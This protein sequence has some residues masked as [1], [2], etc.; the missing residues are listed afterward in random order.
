MMDLVQARD[1]IGKRPLGHPCARQ[2]DQIKNI[3]K[4]I[5]QGLQ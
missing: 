1:S 5:E 3:I 4:K 2:E